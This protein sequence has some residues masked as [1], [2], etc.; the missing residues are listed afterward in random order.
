MGN[1][2]EHFSLSEFSCKDESHTPVPEHLLNNV[3]VLAVALEVIRHA[4]GDVPVTIMSGYRTPA[5]NHLC[6]GAPLSEH[7]NGRAADIR[8]QG[9]SP[10]RVHTIILHLIAAKKIP[11]GGV[12]VYGPPMHPNGW[13]HYDCR[14]ALARW[15]EEESATKAA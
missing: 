10:E 15:N 8:V 11:Q 9:L 6:G 1:L 4:C 13:V 14:G 12:G 5:Y 2:T 3:S 7:V